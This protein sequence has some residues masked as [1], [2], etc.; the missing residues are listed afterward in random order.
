MVY[1]HIEIVSRVVVYRH[2]NY[3]PRVMVDRRI[4]CVAIAMGYIY[5]ES[6]FE[7]RLTDVLRVLLELWFTGVLRGL[8]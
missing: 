2:I 5:I 3:D 7:L 8:I 6:V 1:G 4:E